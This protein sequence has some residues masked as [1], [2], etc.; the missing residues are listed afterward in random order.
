M[1]SI[2]LEQSVLQRIVKLYNI[3]LVVLIEGANEKG[4]GWG[5]NL[6]L[7]AP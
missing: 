5:K 7:V 2:T 1:P 4:E 3:P 6:N